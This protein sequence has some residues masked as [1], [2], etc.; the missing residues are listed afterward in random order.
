MPYDTIRRRWNPPEAQLAQRS[1]VLRDGTLHLTVASI[2]SL[3]EFGAALKADGFKQLS[4][5]R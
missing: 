2:H 4:A 3:E 5:L 1:S